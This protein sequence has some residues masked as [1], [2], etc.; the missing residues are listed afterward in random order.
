MGHLIA[1]PL[2]VTGLQNLNCSATVGMGL[3]MMTSLVMDGW[4]P[5]LVLCR[6]WPVCLKSCLVSEMKPFILNKKFDHEAEGPSHQHQLALCTRE[7][8][9]RKAG[10]PV[11]DCEG[12][13]LGVRGL[14]QSRPWM[15]GPGPAPHV[16]KNGRVVLCHLRVEKT[17]VLRGKLFHQEG[18]LQSVSDRNAANKKCPGPVTPGRGA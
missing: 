6:V 11:H 13:H 4:P 12:Q 1:K 15:A 17:D 9:E 3:W 14:I 10:G 2:T 16:W 8:T 7:R 18:W 5:G